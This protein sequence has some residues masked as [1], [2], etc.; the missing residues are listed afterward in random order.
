MRSAHRAKLAIAIIMLSGAAL[1]LY[2]LDTGQY[3]SDDELVVSRAYEISH[4]GSLAAGIRASSG[5]INGPGL[6]YLLAL[7]LALSPDELLAT[8]IVAAVNA[9]AVA[10]AYLFAGNVFGRRVGLIFAL[11]I[12][13]NPYLVE[14]S[15]RP[16]VQALVAPATI[17]A[18]WAVSRALQRRG[19]ISW[20]VVG[21]TL[22]LGGQAYLSNLANGPA[23]V[24]AML[25]FVLRIG[26][27]GPLTALLVASACIVPL[28]VV[29]ANTPAVGSTL[30][31]IS[32]SAAITI[33]QA[34]TLVTGVA[35][36][37]LTMQGSR[38]LDATDGIF[39]AIDVVAQ[40][41]AAVGWCLLVGRV[42]RERSQNIS[43]T[44]LFAALTVLFPIIAVS[45][46]SGVGKFIPYPNIWYLFNLLPGLLLGTALAI[47]RLWQ[48]RTPLG[49]TMLTLVA[50]SQ[51]VLAIPFF[52]TQAEYWTQ[53]GYGIPWKYNH[54]I[55]QRVAE[56]A[57]A[58]SGFVAVGQ[59]AAESGADLIT[60][61]LRR[62]YSQVQTFDD[63]DGLVF[64]TDA[65]VLYFLLTNDLREMTRFLTEELRLS[66]VLV[67]RLPGEGWT[68]RVV[69]ADR[70]TLV[71]WTDRHLGPI[72]PVQ[73]AGAPTLTYERAGILPPASREGPCRLVVLW[74]FDTD[75]PEPLIMQLTLGNGTVGATEDHFPYSV[76]SLRR[77]DWLYTQMMNVYPI[78]LALGSGDQLSVGIRHQGQ[79]SGRPWGDPV[80]FHVSLDRCVA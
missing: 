32:N 68:R 25:P 63:H 74:R 51:V 28:A 72:S 29:N 66:E 76:D 46:F 37:S 64:R 50:G 9:L 57:S 36:Q 71:G 13:V 80:A 58:K 41:L 15:R 61:S 5:L 48:L 39:P 22:G 17:A 75:P 60:A 34:F 52:L 69:E 1:R 14:S 19:I 56:L 26:I 45:F 20:V 77:G 47:D 78:P 2:S 44:Y 3:T 43:A 8:R 49:A 30:M 21:A 27:L 10:L 33:A 42:W 18:I 59:S 31:P 54:E 62:K 65:E 79:Y 40:A 12:A 73:F 11:L 24:A 16:W 35:Y 23:F 6:P 55:V 70:S 38:I 7:P 67:Q 53:G 4:S